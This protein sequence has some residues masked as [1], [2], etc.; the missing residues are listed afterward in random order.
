MNRKG[1]MK[2]NIVKP[3]I[4]N[5]GQTIKFCRKTASLTQKELGLL[6]GFPESNA[7]IRVAQYESNVR[8]PREEMTERIAQILNVSKYAISKPNLEN[9]LATIHV[10]MK[11]DLMYGLNLSKFGNNM[12]FSFSEFSTDLRAY[13]ELWYS[14]QQLLLGGIIDYNEYRFM[15]YGLGA[16]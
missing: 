3:I 15:M 11:I 12:C 14:L 8:F 10:L 5:P 1:R 9:E 13:S 6:L 16:V 7:E 4:C 2:M